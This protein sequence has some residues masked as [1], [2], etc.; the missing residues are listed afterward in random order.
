VSIT[1]V[2]RNQSKRQ[3]H[4]TKQKPIPSQG[5]ST[6]SK[7]YIMSDS[8]KINVWPQQSPTWPKSSTTLSQTTNCIIHNILPNIQKR[9][10]WK[11]QKCHC[12]GHIGLTIGRDVPVN[13]PVLGICR[14]SHYPVLSGPGKIIN[15]SKFNFFQS[16]V[17]NRI[18]DKNIL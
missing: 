16:K 3:Y 14:V 11:S 15:Q 2:K 18:V 9:S 17:L 8:L 4:S 1:T 6:E 7:Y 5:I 10:L 12:L 13:H